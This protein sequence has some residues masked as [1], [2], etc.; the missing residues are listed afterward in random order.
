M[1]WR[2]RLDHLFIDGNWV[3]PASA[4]HLM[5]VSP[6]TEEVIAKVPAA[7]PADVDRAVSAAR[8]AFVHGPW[9]RFPLE[10]RLAVLQ[11]LSDSLR[12]HHDEHASV[13]TEEMGCPIS[14][15]RSIQVTA[16][17]GIL[18]TALNTAKAYPFETTRR[19]E[20]NHA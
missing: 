3:Q 17:R 1:P 19:S 2:D 20:T 6:K 14:Q 11:R 15:S 10:Q 9:P 7:S 5:V 4:E 18:D 16:A 12:D 8:R 13:M